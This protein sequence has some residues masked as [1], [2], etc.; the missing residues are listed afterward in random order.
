MLT[1]HIKFNSKNYD[2]VL[3][4]SD[5]HFNHVPRTWSLAEKRLF[6]DI[7]EHDEWILNQF[8]NT[9]LKDIIFHLGDFSLNSSVEETLKY[10]SETSAQILLWWG[11][12]ESFTSR[13]YQKCLEDLNMSGCQVYPLSL[14]LNADGS[15]TGQLGFRSDANLVFMGSESTL[16]IDK[17]MINIHHMA[18]LVWDQMKHG[19]WSICGHSHGSLA[20]AT[21][22]DKN[23]KQLDVGV[24]NAKKYNGTCF[25]SFED[26]KNIMETKN[27]TTHDHHGNANI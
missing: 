15:Y 4:C 8:K 7:R 26:I 10:I 1:K 27:V 14:M 16:L 11:N 22:E 21:I 20:V 9:T 12:H 5:T 18:P 17:Q 24:E 6:K 13:I 25:F 2:H 3:F 19:A 23:S